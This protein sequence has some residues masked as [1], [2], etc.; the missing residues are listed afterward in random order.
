MIGLGVGIDYALFIVT[1]YREAYNRNGGDVAGAV[2]E[3]MNTAG[4]AVIFAGTTVVIALMGMFALGVSFLYGLAISSSVAVL[5]VLAASLTLLPALL[6]FFGPRIG[7]PGVL[8]RRRKTPHQ[9]RSSFWTRWITTIQ[10]RPWLAFIASA[11]LMLVLAS[12]ALG[13]RLGNT[14]AGN[15]PKGQT[16]RKA[17]DLLAQGFGKGFSGPL[18]V[19]VKLPAAGDTAALAQFTS[20]LRRRPASPPSR[21]RA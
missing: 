4:R 12:P 19:A 2:E 15:D 1:R 9:D 6:T 11:A 17:Y 14:D 5:L 8:A 13:L 21:R 7:K 16:T 10:R 18:L 20:A 3:A